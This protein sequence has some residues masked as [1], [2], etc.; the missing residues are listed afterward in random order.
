MPLLSLL[1]AAPLLMASPA[2]AQS[3]DDLDE[4]EGSTTTSSSSRNSRFN[5]DEV[6][7]EIVKGAYAKINVGG[8]GYLLDFNGFVSAGTAVGLSLG[9]DFVDREKTSMAGEIGIW[10]GIHNGCSVERQVAPGQL[11]TCAGNA[12]G[13]LSPGIQGDLRTYSILADYEFSKYPT[14]RI[15]LGFRLGGGVLF[16]PL[17]IE[18]TAWQTQ[19][20]VGEWG[21]YDPG[22]HSGPKPLGFGGLTAEYYSKIS[23]FSVGAD[24]DVFYA[25]NFDLGFNGSGYLKYTF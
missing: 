12:K 15:G 18:E 2:Y 13:K 24:F 6:V 19:I 11:G 21:G 4:G 7:R 14:R 25:V 16:S 22:Y 10:Q 8:A 23:H 1:I 5:N 20:V 3:V 9:Y 17:L